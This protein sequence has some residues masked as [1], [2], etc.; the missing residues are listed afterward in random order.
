MV[1]VFKNVGGRFTVK[2]YHPSSFLSVVINVFEKLVNDRLVDHPAKCGLFCDFQYGF[3]LR[4]WA[5]RAIAL[6]VSK[7]FNRVWHAILLHK[8]RSYGIAAQIFGLISS[9][10]SNR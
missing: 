2:N 8:F 7:A 5:T 1:P 9:F 3:R 10:L 6:D 4:L